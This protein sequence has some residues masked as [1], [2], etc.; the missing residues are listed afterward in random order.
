MRDLLHVDDLVEL[1]TSSWPTPSAGRVR[2]Q[3]RR[4]PRGQPLAARDDRDLPRADRATGRDRER[5]RR[6]ARATSR[7]TS[8]T[9]MLLRPPA[10]ARPR[11][12]RDAR[13][14]LPLDR[15]ARARRRAPAP[16]EAGSVAQRSSRA[17]ADSSAPS[18]WRISSSSRASTWS[19][20]ERHARELL[21]AGGVDRRSPSG[22]VERYPDFRSIELDIRDADGVERSSPSRER[23]ELVVH[24]AA[25][26]SHDWAA[27]DP[28]TDFDRSTPTARSTCSRPTRRTLP[29][30]TFVFCSTNK[31][32]GD[33]P[34]M[35]PLVELETRLELPEDHEY[36]ARHRRRRCRS[37]L[38]ALA[39]RRLEG[40]G[41]PAG[42]G[43]RALLR[44]ADRLLPRRLPDRAGPRRA[45][46][47]T[48]SS[49]T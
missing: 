38:D 7:S 45:P 1:S 2:R 40:G 25:Q 5:C 30:A 33:R 10:G 27:R 47:C 12:A 13:G 39:L 19:A 26:P 34:N 14:D 21:R 31:V 8:P 16:V 23:L 37:T 17:P 48:A 28:Q 6:P 43:V 42:A 46:S 49:P 44:D 11:A 35:L 41:R 3:R 22:C 4:R 20:R 32:Y 9:A 29:E 18:P 15:R 24:A 36:Y